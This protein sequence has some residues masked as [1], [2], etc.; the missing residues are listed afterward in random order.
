MT[1]Q[2]RRHTVGVRLA[3]RRGAVVRF[4]M[5][6]EGSVSERGISEMSVWWRWW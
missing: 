2:G 5:R 1:L 3:K 6:E 4:V